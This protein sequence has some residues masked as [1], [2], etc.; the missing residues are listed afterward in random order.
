MILTRQTLKDFKKYYEGTIVKLSETD[1]QLYGIK[2]ITDEFV[3]LVAV[4]SNGKFEENKITYVDIDNGY[5]FNFILPR[6]GVF[7]VDYNAYFLSRL[8]QKQWQKGICPANTSIVKLKGSGEWENIPST[9]FTKFVYAYCNKQQY[10]SL[11]DAWAILRTGQMHSL[12]LSTRMSLSS[13][14]DLFVDT[15]LI[16]RIKETSKVLYL[17]KLFLGMVKTDLFG[18]QTYE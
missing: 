18:V 15:T 13:N 9:Q 6:K 16:G 11:D 14:G 5:D 7:L 2:A 1:D 10:Y 8:P 4:N 3:E 17:N 12:P